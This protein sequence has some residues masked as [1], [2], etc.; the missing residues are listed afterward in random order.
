MCERIHFLTEPLCEPLLPVNVAV[1]EANEVAASS[2]SALH[3]N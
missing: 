3:L 2:I 1:F